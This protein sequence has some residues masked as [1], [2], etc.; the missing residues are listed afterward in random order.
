[1]LVVRNIRVST[2]ERDALTLTWEVAPTTEDVASYT[3]TVLRSLSAAGPY[4]PVSFPMN[5]ADYFEF[6]DRG[7]NIYSKWREFFYRIQITSSG[8][9]SLEYGSAPYKDV[10]DGKDPG[11]V[12][13]E[14]P[15]DIEAME[16]IRR[17]DLLLQEYNGKEV[18]V[19]IERT[20][21]QRCGN[22]WDNLKR[23]TNNAN[24]ST[25]FST[26]FAGGFMHPQVT[27]CM[28]PP[29]QVMS[30][31][32]E[33]FELH[34][35]DVLMWFNARPR[36]KPRDIVIGIDGKRY[37]VI[38]VN[39]SEKGQS[40]TRQTAQLREISRDQVEYEIPI[41]KDA[42]GKDIFTVGSARQYIKATD[43]ESYF[44]AKQ[45]L[46]IEG[47]EDNPIR[48]MPQDVEES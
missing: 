29:H 13:M 40:L 35:K 33:I 48:D 5:A 37:R 6:N 2:L 8:G 24:C 45:E 16:A 15:P 4:S 32:T 43:I 9:E 1:M 26:G 23:R 34:P 17:F 39:R 27:R 22:C 18:L 47:G 38:K 10:L 42:W 7:V 41:D 36:L 25:C 12:T 20:W 31:L 44:E 3:A 19:L 46:G 28:K 14:Y 30:A 21:G 11:G